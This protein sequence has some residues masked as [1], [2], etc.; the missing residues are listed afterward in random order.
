MYENNYPNGNIYTSGNTYHYDQEQ[1]KAQK[2][3]KHKKEG[4]GTGKKIALGICC[5]LL[6]GIF[7]GLGFEAVTTATDFVKEKTQVETSAAPKAE[8][9]S[10]TKIEETITQ[11]ATENTIGTASLSENMQTTTV[12]DVTSVV[13]EVMPAV[14]SVNNK[15]VE[16]T[17][18][19]GQQ[20]SSEGYSTGSGI[21]VGQNDTELLLVTNYHVVESAEELT[22]QFVDGTQA[23]A[24][25]KGSDADKD[26]AVI[27]VQLGDI[28]SSTKEEIAIAKLGNSDDLTVGEPVIAIGNAL[29]Y[30]QSVTTGVVSA[31]NRAIAVDNATSQKT[32]YQKDSEVN[33]FIQTDA[34]I[35]PGNSGGALLNM[36]GEVIGINSNKIGGSAVEGMGYAIPISD[37]KP[38][39]EDL[40]TKQ[41][42]LK[43]DESSKGYLGIT[44]IDV[45]AEYSEIY[46]MP[47]GVYISSVSEGTGAA[48]AGLIKGDIITAL[49][50]EEVKSMDDLKNELSYYAAGTT[51]ELTIM[52]GSPTG[53]Q[54]KTVEV[55]LGSAVS[56]Q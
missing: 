56:T 7:A 18:F 41:T 15:Y 23:Q 26:L 55:T 22:V 2:P 49:N 52:Q 27:A 3:D 38:I 12:T 40:M 10:E 33:T 20:Y 43:V 48:R 6:F 51:V 21:I 11:E 45:V 19:W 13:K 46:G 30:G 50:G 9:S 5:G 53:Y 39:I 36:K 17:S 1:P 32:N 8:E 16:T 42:K 28:D 47:Q 29:G 44:G 24:Q 54:A 25:I 35:N 31:L 34:A 4:T 14:V 37:A